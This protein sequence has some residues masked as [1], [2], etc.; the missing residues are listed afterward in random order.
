MLLECWKKMVRDRLLG[1]CQVDR[2]TTINMSL[3]LNFGCVDLGCITSY[4]LR[5]VTSKKNHPFQRCQEHLLCIIMM[6]KSY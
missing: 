1:M 3:S 5:D 4:V 6:A 2:G